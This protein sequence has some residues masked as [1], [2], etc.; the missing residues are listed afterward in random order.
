MYTSRLIKATALL[1][2]TR[3]LLSAWHPAHSTADNLARLRR[4]N[5]FGKASA[6]RVENVTR[7]FRQRYFDDPQVGLALVELARRP[8]ASGWLSPLLYFFAAQ[9]DPTLRDLALEVVW[10]RRRAGYSE[11]PV[12]LFYRQ[13]RDWVAAG[14]TTSAWGE[15]TIQSVGQHAAATLRDFGLLS[16]GSRKTITAPRLPLPAFALIA[17]WLRERLRAGGAVLHSPDWGLFLL[18]VAAVERLFLDAHQHHLLA[19]HAAGSLVRLDFP[20]ETLDDYARWL[21]D[22]AEERRDE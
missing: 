7:I 22:R 13:L 19:Y 2:D 3:L 6:R 14:Q 9:N 15:E 18:D 10:P 1:A 21:A 5:V 20:A 12:E 4:E 11:M 16:G 17:F 8:A